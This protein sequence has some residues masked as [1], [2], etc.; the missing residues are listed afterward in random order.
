VARPVLVGVRSHGAATCRSAG[1]RHLRASLDLRSRLRRGPH[2][3]GGDVRAGLDWHSTLMSASAEASTRPWGVQ[4]SAAMGCADPTQGRTPAIRPDHLESPR[5]TTHRHERALVLCR[6]CPASRPDD[7]TTCRPSSEREEAADEVTVRLAADVLFA[8]DS[9]DSADLGDETIEVLSPWL[10]S[11]TSVRAG[12]CRWS[13]T[14]TTRAVA[15][16]TST[17]PNAVPAPWLDAQTTRLS[18]AVDGRA[19][20]DRPGCRPGPTCRPLPFAGGA[21]LAGLGG[22][23]PH[24]RDC[25]TGGTTSSWSPERAPCPRGQV[26]VRCSS[27]RTAVP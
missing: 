20:D 19:F 11:S 6:G 24:G 13:A 17:C 18:F 1:T 7:E 23:R 5:S 12:R 21:R 4:G 3:R 22:A 15:T 27:E 14:P 10:P 26:P 25:P 9:A 2:Q 16:T 8:F